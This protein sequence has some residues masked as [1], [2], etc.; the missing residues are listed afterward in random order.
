MKKKV[1]KNIFRISLI[2]S[3]IGGAVLPVQVDAANR[4]DNTK[5]AHRM[6]SEF[7]DITTDSSAYEAIVWAKNRGIIS[8]NADGTFN[9]NALITEAQFAK[10]LSTFLGLKN[11]KEDLRKHTPESHWADE[12]YNQLA[13]YGTPLNGYFDNTLRDKLVKRGV[14]VQ[15]I[16]HLTGNTTSL[17][18]AINFM[19]MKGIKAGPFF[20][21]EGQLFGLTNDLTT[22]QAV[23]LLSRMNKAGLQEATVAVEKQDGISLAVLANKGISTLDSSFR[24][25][26]QGTENVYIP[27]NPLMQEPELPNGCEIVS[28]TAI[29]NYYGYEV[30]K[31]TMADQYLP[32]QDFSYKDGKIFGPDPYVAYA[33]NPRSK[34]VGWYSFAPPI[35]E[36]ANLYMAS[37]TNKM[38]ATDISGSS[39][40][41]IMSL[42]NN[43]VPVVIWT[44][45]D[46]SDPK[47]SGHWYLSDTGQ[48]YKAYTNLHVVVLNGYKE[49]VVH[50]MN[51]L[52]GQ[53]EYNLDAFFKSY[54]EMGKHAV[55]LEKDEAL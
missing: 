28:L 38:K 46:L 55:V 17:S 23:L 30:S 44:T 54:E 2:G 7:K 26:E 4:L 3:L 52:K 14:V 5:V 51:P 40:E 42:L 24:L 8:Q 47:L 41:E 39:K 9:P 15:A 10:M 27:V 6:D 18:E 31:T 19:T 16:G 13:T 48:Y 20:P 53:V 33:G 35:V 11:D 12:Y 29:L 25:G 43:G 21:F 34:K 22:A 49:N 45:L 50:V 37:Q 1:T 32:K 36:A